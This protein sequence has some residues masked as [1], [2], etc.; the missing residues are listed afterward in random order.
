MSNTHSIVSRH[1]RTEVEANRATA[2]G[3]RGMEHPKS[4]ITQM[5]ML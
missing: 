2:P 3:I 4:E 1:W 5:K